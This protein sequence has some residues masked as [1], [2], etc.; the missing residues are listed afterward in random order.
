MRIGLG[1]FVAEKLADDKGLMML[2]CFGTNGTFSLLLSEVGE[3]IRIIDE[4]GL[5]MDKR[6]TRG[7]LV[8]V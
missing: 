5:A 6:M 7:P 2:I 3:T 4:F 1:N 8:V